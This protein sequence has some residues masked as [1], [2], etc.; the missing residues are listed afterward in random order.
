MHPSFV[1]EAA[2][3]SLGGSKRSVQY[4]SRFVRLQLIKILD[5]GIKGRKKKLQIYQLKFARQKVIYYEGSNDKLD[6]RGCMGAFVG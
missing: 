4:T 1:F 6:L 3:I 5:S 2:K